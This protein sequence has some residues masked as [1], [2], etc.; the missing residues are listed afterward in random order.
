ML[1]QGEI[2]YAD[3]MEPLLKVVSV[4]ALEGHLLWLRFSDN[5]ERVFDARPLFEYPVFARLKNPE[6]FKSVYLDYGV[7]TWCNGEIDV[8]PESL[9][10]ESSSPIQHAD[11]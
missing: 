6:T 8:A 11:F 5:E 10:E 7:P 9:Y 3:K 4:R 1:I 2:V